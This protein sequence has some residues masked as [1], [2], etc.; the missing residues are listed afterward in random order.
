VTSAG[1]GT[2]EDERRMK[3][4]L[5]RWFDVVSSN[6]V[7]IRDEEIMLFVESDFGV[8]LLFFLF[9]T[10]SIHQF[11]ITVALLAVSDEKSRSNLLFLQMIV[12][13]WQKLDL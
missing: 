6:P 4:E 7:L 3:V 9:L 12:L 1:A 10:S 11:M 13:N 8:C 2:E 5:Q